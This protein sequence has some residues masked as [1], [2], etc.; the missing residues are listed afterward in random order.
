MPQI[1]AAQE[2][3]SPAAVWL[4][5]VRPFSLTLSIAPVAA[6]AALAWANAGKL[7]WP[8]LAAAAIASALIQIGTN[9][10]N[11]AADYL[12]GAHRADR[13]GPLSVVARGLL[14]PAALI[15]AAW[16]SFAC[17]ALAGLYL[18]YVGGWP[19]LL[20]G[21]LSIA[22]GWAYTGG[23]LPI[24]YTP[25]AEL[26]VIAFFGVGAVS[27]TYWLCTGT[28]GAAAIVCGLAIGCFAAAVLLV[29]NY[30]DIKE[31]KRVGRYTIAIALGPETARALYA[32]MMAAPFGLLVFLGRLMP[33][34]HVWAAF[35]SVP[36]AISLIARQYREPPGPG[37]T[38]ILVRTVQTQTLFTALLSI[39]AVL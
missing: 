28:L 3:P 23:P 37:L 30:R 11:D 19:I 15:R 13:V 27:G 24:A 22:C 38:R 14:S 33:H 12:R 4:M 1:T 5:A 10:Y 18:V 39:G 29:N 17:A 32:A 36:L 16:L 8:V 7:P 9:L 25:L 21:V 35:A 2:P 31:D 6:G 34:T 20:L 26:F